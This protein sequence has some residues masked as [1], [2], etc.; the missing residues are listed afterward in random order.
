[1]KGHQRILNL[2]SFFRLSCWYD[3]SRNKK[4][5]D[6]KN[7]CN[8]FMSRRS[9][10][11]FATLSFITLSFFVFF[12][13]NKILPTTAVYCLNIAKP[14]HNW[15]ATKLKVEYKYINFIYNNIYIY[16]YIY[17]I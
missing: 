16:I 15:V 4:K 14:L 8:L 9:C 10:M 17:I 2:K 12:L 13:N 3:P 11:R 7:I 5:R 1:M 6:K